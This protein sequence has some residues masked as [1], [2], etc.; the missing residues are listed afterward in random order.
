MGAWDVGQFSNDTALDFADEI[1]TFAEVRKV[2]EDDSKFAPDLDADEACIALAACEML[3]T[4][5]GRPPEDL[6]DMTTF[7]A[8][9]VTSA[10]L[11]TAVGLIAHIRSNSEL[12]DLWA[13]ADENDAWQASLEGLLARLDQSKPFE[14]SPEKPKK[15]EPPEDFIGYCYICYGMVTERDGLHFTYDDPDGGSLSSYPHRK[16]VEERVTEPGPYWNEDG[17]PTPVMRKVLMQGLGYEV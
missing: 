10:L 14:A 16:C 5:I 17:S 4:A 15:E 2:L 7:D 13:E 1:K 12:A 3:A 11:Q 8:E 6:P 9:E